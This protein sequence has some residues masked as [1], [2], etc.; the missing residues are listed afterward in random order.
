MYVLIDRRTHIPTD[1]RANSFWLSPLTIMSGDN[2]ASWDL[3]NHCNWI[4]AATCSPNQYLR[5]SHEL[6]YLAN[7][8]DPDKM[9]QYSAFHQSLH[10]LLR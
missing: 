5:K 2:Q 10:C 6:P 4:P 9:Q 8:E 7:N 1:G 3:T